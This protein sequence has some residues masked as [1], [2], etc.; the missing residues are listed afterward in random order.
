MLAGVYGLYVWSLTLYPEPEARG[1]A[2]LALVAGN[3]VLALADAS[4]AG[5]P[6]FAPHRKFYW[7]ITSAAGGILAVVLLVPPLAGAFK[8]APPHL[9]LLV[10]ALTVA[11]VSGGW[12]GAARSLRRRLV[13]H[14]PKAPDA[15]LS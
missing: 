10:V 9:P 12:S 7:A 2:F 4:S 11:G 3:L 8:V 15:L 1:A 14:E 13:R 5:G 6:L